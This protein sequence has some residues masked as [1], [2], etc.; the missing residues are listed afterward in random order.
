MTANMDMEKGLRKLQ[1]LVEEGTPFSGCTICH[2]AMVGNKWVSDEQHATAIWAVYDPE[3]WYKN[4]FVDIPE[5]PDEIE[6]TVSKAV[7]KTNKQRLISVDDSVSMKDL[8]KNRIFGD[9]I[10]PSYVWVNPPPGPED[11]VLSGIS[12]SFIDQVDVIGGSSAD[13][14]VTGKWKQFC[15]DWDLQGQD[16]FH[17]RGNSC[18]YVV[19]Y[20]SA[21]VKGCAFTGYSPTPKTGTITEVGK[22][23]NGQKNPRCLIS[24]DNKPVHEVYNNWTSNFF[25]EQMSNTSEDS[26]ILGPSSVYPLG[27]IVAHDHNNEPVYRTLHPHLFSPAKKYVTVFSD[28]KV[29]EDICMM[30][31]TRDNIKNRISAVAQEVQKSANVSASQIKGALVVFCAGAMM[32]LNSEGEQNMHGACAKLSDSLGGANYIGIHTFG[33]QGPFPDGS[34]RHGNLMFSALVYTSVRKVMMLKNVDDG[35]DVVQEGGEGPEQE[36]FQNIV[37]NDCIVGQG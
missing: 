36:K 13:N 14:D 24:I 34:N 33:E 23:D 8:R 30:T 12:K 31:G 2:G 9:K 19:A 27:Q 37:M 6:K 10:C 3:G 1:S 21:V 4:G 28:C 35:T 11:L 20:A 32:Y 26:N 29:D 7:M 16:K 25:S 5:N 15:S 17:I 18:T 22:H